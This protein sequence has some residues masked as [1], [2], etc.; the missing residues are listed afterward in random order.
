[1][2]GERFGFGA[3][4]HWQELQESVDSCLRGGGECVLSPDYIYW[5][6]ALHMELKGALPG[7]RKK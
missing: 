1:M 2:R 7:R 6:E 5:A 3:C 4:R